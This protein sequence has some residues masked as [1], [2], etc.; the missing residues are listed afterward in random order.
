M[1][2]IEK[3]PIIFQEPLRICEPLSWVEHIPCAFLLVELL[4]PK[5][6]V[7]LGVHTGNSFC[8]FCQAVK[9]L[10]LDTVCYGVDTFRGD[11]QAGFYDSSVYEGL[12]AYVEQQYGA[13]AYLLK[14]TF[15]D[16]R[17]KFLDD[18]IDLLHIDGLHTFEAVKEDFESWLPKMSKR[19]VVLFHDINEREDDFGV[20]KLWDRMRRAIRV[21]VLILVMGWVWRLWAKKSLLSCW[22]FWTP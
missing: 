21:L 2:K 10:S 5:V 6:F 11:S 22:N 19:G 13:N 16:A 3:Y 4:R 15:E 14:M 12:F 8:A 9:H 7:E 1:F 18:N 17:A 20:W